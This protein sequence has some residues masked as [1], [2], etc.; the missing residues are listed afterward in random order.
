MRGRG[1]GCSWGTRLEEGVEQ[2]NAVRGDG[3]HVEEDRLRLA[4]EGVREE[5][6]LDHYE[7]VGGGLAHQDHAVVR[8]LVGRVAKDLEELRA[9]Q[10]EH[11]LRVERESRRHSEGRR[12]VLAVVAKLCDQ[13]DEHPIDPPEDVEGLLGLRLVRGDPSHQDRRGLLVEARRDA[14]KLSRVSPGV[15]ERR[16]AQPVLPRSVL[17]R[18]EELTVSLLPLLHRLVCLVGHF[19]VQSDS[20]VLVERAHRPRARVPLANLSLADRSRLLRK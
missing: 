9:P 6:R 5:S 3:S 4:L 7:R 11:E 18:R 17:V 12:V 1:R 2:E 16:N 13:A 14:L 20:R 8:R 10:V 15:G 19:K